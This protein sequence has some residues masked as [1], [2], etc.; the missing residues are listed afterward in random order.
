MYGD[1][2]WTAA[3][4]AQLQLAAQSLVD[5]PAAAPY[6]LPRHP[7]KLY[8]EQTEALI[9]MSPDSI[10]YACQQWQDK[11]PLVNTPFDRVLRKLP[12]N[13]RP[14][15]AGPTV[16]PMLNPNEPIW[17]E[18]THRLHGILKRQG[19]RAERRRKRRLRS[20]LFKGRAKN[21][22]SK[23]DEG[24]ELRDYLDKHAFDAQGEATTGV[25]A[26]GEFLE[27]VHEKYLIRK[28]Q[29]ESKPFRIRGVENS[30][31]GTRGIGETTM[32]KP[33][34]VRPVYVPPPPSSMVGR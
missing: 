31:P 18:M 29:I 5:T 32:R 1:S 24:K 13:V 28:E 26:P 3:P 2:G 15:S 12:P 6:K 21:A 16:G 9:K 10:V 27:K 25:S 19:K 34:V 4:E 17:F 23:R 30:L 14:T 20:K 11:H 33:R 7:T 22:P 8:R